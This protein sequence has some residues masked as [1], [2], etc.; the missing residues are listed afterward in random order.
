M[1]MAVARTQGLDTLK[2]NKEQHKSIAQFLEDRSR[3]EER[4]RADRRFR[5]LDPQGLLL[6]VSHP[7]GTDVSYR[8]MPRDLSEMGLGFLHGNFLYPGST[9]TLELRGKDGKTHCI[10]AKLMRCD[11]VTGR[12]HDVGIKFI[13]AIDVALYIDIAA[14]TE[15]VPAPTPKT[16]PSYWRKG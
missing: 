2:L 13:K 6:F 11:H 9:C 12:V 4:R 16:R 15:A 7:G 14:D 10:S 5:F 3:T 1:F 8:V